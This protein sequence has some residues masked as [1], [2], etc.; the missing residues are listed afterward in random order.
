VPYANQEMG[1]HLLNRI[2]HGHR[3]EFPPSVPQDIVDLATAC[4]SD[5]REHRPSA[6]SVLHAVESADIGVKTPRRERAS[7]EVDGPKQP[8]A[9]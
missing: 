2:I 8:R 5:T 9:S 1:L 4:W 3:P 6:V 7:L